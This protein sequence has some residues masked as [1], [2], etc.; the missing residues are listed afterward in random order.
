MVLPCGRSANTEAGWMKGSGK[1][2]YVFQP[3]PQEPELM[4]KIF[5][6]ILITFEQLE[7]QFLTQMTAI[8]KS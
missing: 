2:V 3:I 1:P 7:L 6:R 4:Y 8:P 5:D